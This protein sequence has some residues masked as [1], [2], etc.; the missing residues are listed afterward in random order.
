MDNIRFAKI[1]GGTIG[2]SQVV[3]GMVTTRGAEGTIKKVTNAKVR[4]ADTK[5][6][7]T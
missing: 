1:L 7:V 4:S 5:F 3:H 6:S 2:D